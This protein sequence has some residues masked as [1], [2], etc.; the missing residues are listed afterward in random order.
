M[1]R[2]I[3]ILLLAVPGCVCAQNMYDVTPLVE[4]SLSGTSR[5]ISMGGSMGALGGDVSVMGTNPAGIALYRN[6]DASITGFLDMRNSKAAYNGTDTDSDKASAGIMNLS[7]V[8]TGKLNNA[9]ALKYVNIGFGYRKSTNLANNFEMRGSPVA[10]SQQYGKDLV[11]SQQYAMK[12]LYDLRPFN[13]NEESPSYRHFD[14]LQFSWIPLMAAYSNLGDADGN[15]ITKPDGS[16]VFTPDYVHFISEERG[17]VDEFDFNISANV[18]DRFYFGATLSVANVEYDYYSRYSESDADG[19]IYSLCTS[20]YFEATGVSLK[21]GAI[22]RPFKYSPFKLGVAVHTPTW[23]RF[24]SSSY[25]EMTGPYGDYY[26]TRYSEMY[27]QDFRTKFNLSTPWK[28]IASA[29]YT[30]GSVMA[31][32]AEYE[33][34]DYASTRFGS[35]KIGADGAQNDE[36]KYNLH[37]QHTMRAGAEFNVGGGISLRAGYCYSTAP[38][39]TTAFKSMENMSVVSTATEFNNKYDKELITFG[40]GYRGKL[41]YFDMAY[42]WKTQ[43]SDFYSYCDPDDYNPAAKVSYSD[44]TITATLGV[45]F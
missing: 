30:F 3:Y 9:S 40:A 15:F 42:V 22:V 5:F 39:K 27:A 6:N 38:F 13:I 31:L 25:S 20:N 32:N 34:M 36:V 33:Y 1:K 7:A 18:D 45:R 44:H 23:Y 19:E 35:F 21:L 24:K 12:Y 16:L 10:Y 43:K 29:S 41:W 14:A 8:I 28:V 11:Y 37:A 17:G 26:D 2:F 4:N